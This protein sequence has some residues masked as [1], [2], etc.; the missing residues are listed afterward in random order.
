MAS[1]GRSQQDTSKRRA[2]GSLLFPA[3]PGSRLKARLHTFC[4]E[5]HI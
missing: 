4:S 2:V 3:A 5:D 1:W